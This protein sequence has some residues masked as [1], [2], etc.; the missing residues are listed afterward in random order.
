VVQGL[1]V[2]ER[3]RLVKVVVFQVDLISQVFAVWWDCLC[4]L[5]RLH[6]CHVIMPEYV[7]PRR[8]ARDR[9]GF[10]FIKWDIFGFCDGWDTVA[11]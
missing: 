9:R 7:C 6:G 3:A 5:P 10:H 8:P 4:A 1:T 2:D 11:P